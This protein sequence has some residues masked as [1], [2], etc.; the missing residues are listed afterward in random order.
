MKKIIAITATIFLSLFF[1]TLIMAPDKAVSSSNSDK[2]ASIPD[3]VTKILEKSC[4]PC[5]SAPGSGMAMMHLN[6]DNWEKYNPEKQ[7]DKAKSICKKATS[8]KMPTSSFKKN[9]PDKIPT[10]KEINTLCNWA[11]SL[12]IKK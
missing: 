7:A 5:H 9:N 1:V 10:E 3:S 2:G 4:Y 11:N 12:E 6:F 8:G